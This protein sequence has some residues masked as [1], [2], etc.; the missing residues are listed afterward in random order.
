V[1]GPFQQGYDA[2]A[3]GDQY[4][5]RT[6]L[7]EAHLD[8]GVSCYAANDNDPDYAMQC[9]NKEW[10]SAVHGWPFCVACLDHVDADDVANMRYMSQDVEEQNDETQDPMLQDEA[11]YER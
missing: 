6:W 10:P 11:D 8:E 4:D 1:F 9:Y 5:H 3:H 7:R 2:G